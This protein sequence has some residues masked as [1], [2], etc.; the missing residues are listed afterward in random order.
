MNIS[1]VNNK[2]VSPTAN[3][4]IAAYSRKEFLLHPLFKSLTMTD[5]AY[6]ESALA[7][8]KWSD[9]DSGV[10]N[11]PSQPQ[12]KIIILGLGE[13]NK[14]HKR[15]MFL[16]IRKVVSMLKNHRLAGATI[17]SADFFIKATS[18]TETLSL[19]AQ[20]ILLADFTF[21]DYKEK[22]KNGW[23]EIKEI[24]I[25]GRPSKQLQR[26]LDEGIII[27]QATNDCRYLSNMPGGLMTPQKL[28]QEAINIGKTIK[29]V[30]V[31]VLHEKE[32]K[33]LGM[34][35][36]IGVSQGSIEKPE[37]IIMEYS[38]AKARKNNREHPLIFVGKGVTF[39]T[40]GLNLKSTNGIYEM[41]MDMSGGAAV[42]HAIE[43]IA[44]LKLP[45]RVIGI[46]PAV[47]N[48]PSGSSYHPGDLLKTITGKTIEVL[49]TDAEGR[50]ILADALGYAQ[51]YK[52][53]LMIDLATLTGAVVVALGQRMSGLFANQTNLLKLGQNIG[54]RTGDFVWPLPLWDEYEEEIRGTFGDVAND[55]KTNYGGAIIGAI[56]L[57]QFVGNFPWMHLDISPTMTTIDGQFLAKG[58]AGAGVRFLVEIARGHG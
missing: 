2:S 46:I 24:S 58:A 13:K 12:R 42:I 54:D 30:K 39:D 22:P 8:F 16:T 6:L 50:I 56:F 40:G 20:N 27:G 17:N 48:M 18:P 21:N 36:V 3:L 25:V 38:S 15:K 37:F 7:D 10:F 43:A 11:L 14:W 19:I 47:E 9:K 51:K 49:N 52:P 34:G 45:I 35:G 55:H 29:A 57:K 26:A 28:A 4:V 53:S 23:P 5:R 1:L 33:K 31:N 44:K 32:I 41:H